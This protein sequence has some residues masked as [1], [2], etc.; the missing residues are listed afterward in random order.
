MARIKRRRPNPCRREKCRCTPL[1]ELGCNTYR[2]LGVPVETAKRIWAEELN[3]ATAKGATG[4]APLQAA[5]DV[6]WRRNPSIYLSGLA[7]SKT[8]AIENV[9]EDRIGQCLA[10]V[11]PDEH[12]EGTELAIVLRLFRDMSGIPIVVKVCRIERSGS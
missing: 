8:G 11:L 1:A 3:Y 9:P 5:S 6:F 2:K 12:F 4:D 7:G 10:T